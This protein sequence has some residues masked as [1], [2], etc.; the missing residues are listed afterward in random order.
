MVRKKIILAALTG[1]IAVSCAEMDDTYDD[2]IKNGEIW[3]TKK[4]DSVW[5]LPGN[6]RAR[7]SVLISSPEV[8]KFRAFWNDGRD[9]VEVPVQKVIGNDTVSTII[10]LAEGSY[11]FEVY[12]YDQNGNASVRKDTSG[13][14]FG[15]T[16]IESLQ[17][18][19]VS[20]AFLIAGQPK[21]EWL[22]VTKPEV[23][24]G[25][26][27]FIGGDGK[28]QVL[29]VPVDEMVTRIADRPQGDSVRYRTL[30]LPVPN[31]IDTFYS[32][33]QTIH[34]EEPVPEL[35]DKGKIA[36]FPLTGDAASSWDL[37]GLWNDN[38]DLRSNSGGFSNAG[39]AFPKWFSFDLGGV[40][41][42]DRFSIWGV[43]DGREY[44]AGNVRQFQ[45]W[46]SNEPAADGGFGGWTLLGEYEVV[47]PSGLPDGELSD[48]D[49]AA[50]AAGVEFSLPSGSPTVRYLRFVIVSTFDTPAG[51]PSGSSWL[52]EMSFWGYG[53]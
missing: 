51:S 13:I 37:Q 6:S 28:G 26:V 4:P 7:L 17:N 52:L 33:Y 41:K 1:L 30:F 25:E 22:E 48:E 23:V 34:L 3:Y 40:N 36:V 12:T 49:R 44:N 38:H 10:E 29:R 42:L 9:S 35:L 16:Y 18:R 43:H 15:E 20:S 11:T 21:I 19:L 47:K 5:V 14:V 39:A 2:F 46:G 45:L 53:L 8:V 50:A 27:H 24:G 32:A 31:A